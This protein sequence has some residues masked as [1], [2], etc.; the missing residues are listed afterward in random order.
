MSYAIESK[1][2]DEIIK[3]LETS[4]NYSEMGINHFHST[5]SILGTSPETSYLKF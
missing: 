4:A 3:E 5:G 1:I 2:K